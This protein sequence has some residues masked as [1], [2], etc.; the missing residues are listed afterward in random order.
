M[1]TVGTFEIAAV[2][3]ANEC[4]TCLSKHYGVSEWK[5][6]ESIFLNQTYMFRSLLRPSIRNIYLTWLFQLESVKPIFQLF[7][8]C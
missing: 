7:I 1:D 6:E 3:A 8:L 5:V 4:V 2:L